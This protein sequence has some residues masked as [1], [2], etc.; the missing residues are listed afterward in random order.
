[1]CINN[2]F[3]RKR[4]AALA[5]AIGLA[6]TTTDQVGAATLNP[7]DSATVNDGDTAENWSLDGATLTVTPGGETGYIQTQRGSTVTINGGNVATTSTYALSLTDSNA[8]L[9][10]TNIVSTASYGLIATTEVRGPL[11]GSVVTVTRSMIQGLGRGV[12]ASFNSDI[13]LDSTS[14]YGTGIDGAVDGGIGMV[15]VGA[16]ATVQNGSTITG[17]NRGV[18]MVSDRFAGSEKSTLTLDNS[19][20]TGKAGSAIFVSEGD[21]PNS[22]AAIDVN[23]GSSLTGGNGVILE[24]EK[25]STVQFNVNN[26]RLIGDVL[27][28]AGST[29]NLDLKNNASL[30]GTIANATSLTIDN[31]SR[32]V[33]EGNSTVGKLSLNDALVDL[34]GTDG[35][36]SF[37]QLNVTELNGSGTFALGT[38]L[39]ANA[40][41]QLNVSGT[42]TGNHKLLVENTGAKPKSGDADR[43][44]VHIEGGDAQFAVDSEDGLVDTGTYAYALEQRANGTGGN[45]WFLVQTGEISKST[46]VAIGLFSAAPT[47][48]YGESATLRSRMGELRIGSNE[49][50]GWMR[51]YGNKYNMSAGSGVEYSQQQQGI[52][53][54]AD[55]PVASSNGQWLIGLMGGYS[56]SDLD[57][58]QGNKGKID[59]YYVGAYSTWLLD[60]GFYIDALIKA[61]RFQNSA[62]VTMRDGAKTKG[63][64]TNHGVGGSVEAG[65]HIS[66]DDGWFVE[67]YAQVSTLW[68]SGEDYTLD[69]GMDASSNQADSVLGKVGSH[70]GRKFALKEGGFVQPYVKAAVAREF[71]TSNK[72]TINESRFHNDLSGTRVELGAGVAAQMT[73]VLQ[74]HAD[75]DYMKGSN[76]EQPWGINVGVRYNW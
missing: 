73:D 17:D 70:A 35:N 60:N 44:L 66:F 23:N 51:T 37:H 7:G 59:S 40:G 1:M 11:T 39:A 74:V 43:Q 54:G 10:D 67:P 28:E 34:R 2:L 53:F 52:S 47:V 61:N 38:D 65:K 45:D 71:V 58:K 32:W 19:S 64:Y 42:A 72:V 30:T 49:G 9:A 75:F 13:T 69:N 20:V 21:T 62:D 27:V 16:T 63:D 36:A 76:I 48:W 57:L 12:S 5:L 4:P 6:F 29:A 18:L 41:D 26:S 55:M 31:S 24:V 46:E 22:V 33:M 56:K 8:T 50:G 14:V 3:F 15:L 25:A 68:V